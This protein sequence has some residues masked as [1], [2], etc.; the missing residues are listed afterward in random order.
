MQERPRPRCGND[1]GELLLRCCYTILLGC[2]SVFGVRRESG[3][4][5]GIIGV[6]RDDDDACLPL[7]CICTLSYYCMVELGL[8]LSRLFFLL[9]SLAVFLQLAT[10]RIPSPSGSTKQ[11]IQRSKQ[12][13]QRVSK[14]PP[15]HPPT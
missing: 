14:P 5:G 12:A 1:R 7:S 2:Q 3:C 9:N 8:F 6:A 13:G 15:T 11:A 10:S 4:S